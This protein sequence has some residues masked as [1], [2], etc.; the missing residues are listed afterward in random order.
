MF[1]VYGVMASGRDGSWGFA[2]GFSLLRKHPFW[3][4]LGTP[5]GN[6]PLK[7]RENIT[8]A[9]CLPAGMSSRMV[10]KCPGRIVANPF[11]SVSRKPLWGAR[12]PLGFVVNHDGSLGSAL[13]LPPFLAHTGATR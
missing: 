2:L 11:F 3:F 10:N 1:C 6:S 4:T 5:G 13:A 8:Q 12:L 7:E 9:L